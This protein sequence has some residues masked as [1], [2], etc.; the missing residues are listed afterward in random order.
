MQESLRYHA[1]LGDLH[2]ALGVG[3]SAAP[4]YR[5][6]AALTGNGTLAELFRARAD[7]SR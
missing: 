5:S 4:A 3:E 2:T 1:T 6:A 7:G